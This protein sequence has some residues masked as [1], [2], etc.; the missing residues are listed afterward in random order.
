MIVIKEK[1]ALHLNQSLRKRSLVISTDLVLI[2]MPFKSCISLV[3]PPHFY[4][5]VGNFVLLFQIFQLPTGFSTLKWLNKLKWRKY[6]LY[7]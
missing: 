6:L 5:W 4:S 7:L 2:T 3:R 1:N